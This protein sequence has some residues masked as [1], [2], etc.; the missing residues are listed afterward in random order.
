MKSVSPLTHNKPSIF[1]FVSPR[2]DSLL[3]FLMQLSWDAK[4][5]KPEVPRPEPE[6]LRPEPECH[7]Q[8]DGDFVVVATPNVMRSK[9][10]GAHPIGF[11]RVA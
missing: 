9:T 6:V 8:R 7:A 2:I 11:W 4:H 10:L 1:E 3:E 5:T